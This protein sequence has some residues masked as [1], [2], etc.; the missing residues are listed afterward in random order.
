MRQCGGWN[1]GL[2]TTAWPRPLEK[3]TGLQ[4]VRR[5]FSAPFYLLSH[6]FSAV[7]SISFQTLKER[8]SLE[9]K[10][11][12]PRSARP[13]IPV[14]FTCTWPLLYEAEVG[15]GCEL[16]NKEPRV[17][18]MQCPLL[19]RPQRWV[20]RFQLLV[21]L[22]LGEKHWRLC[23]LVLS[24]HLLFLKDIVRILSTMPLVYWLDG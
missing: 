19:P 4:N 1:I 8:A 24:S 7:P 12:E 3:T 10:W 17:G 16:M 21:H 11:V 5:S 15:W 6:S 13:L 18:H 23:C 14:D 2:W 22:T 9:M 20:S